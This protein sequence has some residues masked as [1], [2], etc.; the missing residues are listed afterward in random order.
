MAARWLWV[1]FAIFRVLWCLAPQTGYLH[2][3]EFF[4]SPEVMAGDILNLQ[5]YRPW[6]FNT[7]FP[8]RTA[9]FPLLTS[10]AMFWMLQSLQH[11]CLGI[12]AISGYTLLI[13][14]RLCM[15]LLSFMLD[16]AVYHSAPFWR[17]HQ[18]T[19]MLL[20]S[21]SYVTLVFYTRTL[22]NAVEGI[23]FAMLLFLVATDLRN[24]RAATKLPNSHLKHASMIGIVTVAGFFNRPTFLG[25]AAAPVLYW[26]S[27][28]STVNMSP[29]SIAR[30]L[31][32]SMKMVP[33]AVFTAIVFIVA[34]TLYFSSGIPLHG[35]TWTDITSLWKV[36]TYVQHNVVLTPCNFL[37]YNLD[38]QNLAKHG[39]HSRATHFI[40]NSTMLFGVLHVSA[41]ISGLKI[42][43]NSIKKKIM[44]QQQVTKKSQ[45]SMPIVSECHSLLLLFYFTPLTLL[46]LFCHQEPRFLIPLIVPLALFIASQGEVKW[47]TVVIYNI[48]GALMFGWLHQGGIIPG[49]SHLEQV[50]HSRGQGSQLQKTFIFYHTY[51][52]PR[53]LLNTDKKH[54]SVKIIDL[55]GAEEQVLCRV[56]EELIHSTFH[57]GGSEKTTNSCFYVIAPGTVTNSVQSCKILFTNVWS[58]FPH[59]TMEDLP[60]LHSLPGNW[61]SQLSL[62]IFEV[63]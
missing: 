12:D 10:G 54:D 31:Q 57:L 7:S 28:V 46:S 1:L 59:V 52:P 2:P 58:F 63:K 45:R 36:I 49:L 25:F 43:K 11:S 61:L 18:W 8:C 24:H 21:G 35:V 15:T 16:Y 39:I 42:I 60:E 26:L 4:Q 19:S 38:T 29:F 53:F 37:I 17:A 40:I 23:L 33:A 3:D 14:P 5:T 41:V 62:Y 6:E 13:F 22:A 56:L 32:N 51:M 47:K 48:L 44:Q 9:V 34:D 55:F 50:I 27:Q 20:L 30:F